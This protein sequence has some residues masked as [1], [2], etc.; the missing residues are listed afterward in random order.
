MKAKKEVLAIA[1]G[2]G[3]WVQ[4]LRLRKAWEDRLV[5][6]AT[7]NPALYTD[8][9]GKEFYTVPDANRWK[10]MALLKSMF[11]VAALMF[12]LRPRIVITTGAAPGLFAL[13]FGKLFG[14]RTVWIDSIANASEMSL[15][16]RLARHI[17]DQWLTQWEELAGPKGP[18]FHGAVL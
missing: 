1:S 10:K 17:S 9:A 18:H 3:H 13:L 6:Y 12:K 2:G 5:V 11:S 7:V 16:G 14:A 8:V 4:L 15:S